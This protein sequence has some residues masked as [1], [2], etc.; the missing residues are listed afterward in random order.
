MHF[1][2]VVLGTPSHSIMSIEFDCG[3]PPEASLLWGRV[4]IYGGWQT[5]GKAGILR[6]CRIVVGSGR[7]WVLRRGF[8]LRPLISISLSVMRNSGR[9]GT[10]YC[11]GGVSSVVSGT[12][13]HPILAT[14]SIMAGLPRHPV[15]SVD[16]AS[17]AEK[18]ALRAEGFPPPSPS[19]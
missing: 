13:R 4:P 14:A 7:Y 6:R 11:P 3:R 1:V 2:S 18:R 16:G 12:P 5:E 9:S 19:S 10:A 8:T 17:Q 15:F